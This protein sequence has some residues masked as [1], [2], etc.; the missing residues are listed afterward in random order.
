HE[1]EAHGEAKLAA[2]PA[3]LVDHRLEG[4]PDGKARAPADEQHGEA[5]RDDQR[6]GHGLRAPSDHFLCT[7]SAWC[8]A[9][10]VRVHPSSIGPLADARR[11]RIWEVIV[12]TASSR[13]WP[14][15]SKK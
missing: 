4:K 15:G 9:F 6:Y 3:Q 14:F 2:H 11:A 7:Q 10:R 12:S 1:I 8:G 5:D 13:R